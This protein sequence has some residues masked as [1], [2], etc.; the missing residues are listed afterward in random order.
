MTGNAQWVGADG[1]RYVS[2]NGKV[3]NVGAATSGGGEY[4]IKQGYSMILDP[5]AGGSGKTDWNNSGANFI[6]PSQNGVLGME[7]RESASSAAASA[8]AREAAAKTAA[9]ASARDNTQKAI[10]SLD[11]EL[12]VGNQNIDAETGAVRSRY[13]REAQQNESDY[14]EQTVNNNQNLLKNKQNGLQAGAQGIRG[15]RSTLASI[16]ALGGTGL[17]LANRAVTN[18]V[19]Q[20]LGEASE[21]AATNARTLD[22]AIGKFRD[23][24][25]DRRAE[26]ETTARNNRTALEGRVESK[27]QG[28][29]QKMA[30]LFSEIG[31][32]GNAT[33]FLNRAGDL[34]NTIAQKTA[35]AQAPVT[36][37]S[38]AF[39]PGT[40]ADYLAGTGDMTVTTEAGDATGLGTSPSAIL[41]GRKDKERRQVAL[42]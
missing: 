19:N 36:A 34:N 22:S 24:D 26:L 10:N 14:N 29:L 16:G 38:A 32:T 12:A 3:Q 28:F 11:T 13:D 42:A 9:N 40:L 8:A 39:T 6:E 23:E 25:K 41:A 2:T 30:E 35:V 18:S 33:S 27:R 15:L 21:T 31:D 5:N 17:T 7:T 20:D 37:R 4:W 1:N